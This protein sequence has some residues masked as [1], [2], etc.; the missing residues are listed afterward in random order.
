M[1]ERERLD[2]RSDAMEPERSEPAVDDRALPAGIGTRLREA[3]TYV[4]LAEDDVA[5]ALGLPVASISALESGE[6]RPSE[7]DVQ[8]L[9]GIYRRP[10]GWLLGTQDVEL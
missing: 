2:G 6:R 3:R 8:R 4:G 10:I 5:A 9:A 7:A 1:G